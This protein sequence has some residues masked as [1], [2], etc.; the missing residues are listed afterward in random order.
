[1]NATEIE[2]LYLK[3]LDGTLT[4]SESRQLKEALQANEAVAKDLAQYDAIRE[5]ILR[6]SPETFGPYFAQKLIAKIQNSR[7]EID[8]QIAFFFKRFQLAAIGIFVAL[9]TINIIFS[10]E[11]NLP[12][13]LGIQDE[14]T[15]PTP[16]DDE[17]ETFDFSQ[18][19]TNNEND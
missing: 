9:L 17:I 10:E 2:A 11:V 4:E 16:A 3:S 12:S 18:Y 8:Q 5:S 15:A 14:Q 19:L 13:V 7:V 1:M 6:K